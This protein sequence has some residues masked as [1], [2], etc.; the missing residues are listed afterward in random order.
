MVNSHL[1]ENLLNILFLQHNVYIY[2]FKKCLIY[3]FRFIQRS[4][5]T[6]LQSN[7]V[8]SILCCAIAACSLDHKDANSSVMKFITEFIRAATS[9]DVSFRRVFHISITLTVRPCL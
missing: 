4:P 7:M 8:K 1:S 5:L 2:F 9:K 3:P 6:F